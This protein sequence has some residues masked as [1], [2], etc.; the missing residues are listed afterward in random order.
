MWNTLMEMNAEDCM[1][2][3]VRRTVNDHR[4]E[5]DVEQEDRLMADQEVRAVSA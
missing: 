4:G 5:I 3:R 1:S 2:R